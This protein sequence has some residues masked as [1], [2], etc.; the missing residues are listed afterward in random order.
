MKLPITGFQPFGGSHINPS[1]QV[2]LALAHDGMAGVELRSVILPVDRV[3]SAATAIDAIEQFR[4]DAIVSLGQASGRM[5]VS[6]ERVAINLMDYRMADNSGWLNTCSG[7][8]V[9]ESDLECCAERLRE[10]RSVDP[11]AFH[12]LL[13]LLYYKRSV[14]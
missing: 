6:I 9:E 7:E 2:V 8:F 5:A 3:Q 11:A 13:Q 14:C 12:G 10:F 1:E 4:P